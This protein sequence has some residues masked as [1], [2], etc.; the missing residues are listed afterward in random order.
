[1]EVFWH[2][3]FAVAVANMHAYDMLASIL[4]GVCA[5]I[6]LILIIAGERGTVMSPFYDETEKC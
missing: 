3:F 5:L 6:Y 1:M 4:S 2:F